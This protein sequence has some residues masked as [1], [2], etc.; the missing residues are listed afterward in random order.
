M[1][2]MLRSIGSPA[3]VGLLVGILCSWISAAGEPLPERVVVLTFDDASRSHAT[4]VA[5]LLEKYGFGATF[6][7]CEFPPD[8]ATD[9]TKYMT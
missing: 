7:I 2:A 3:I 9:K 6:F 4:F 1:V 8:F 5:P